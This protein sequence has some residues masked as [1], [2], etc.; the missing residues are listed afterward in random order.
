MITRSRVVSALFLWLLGGCGAD[1]ESDDLHAQTSSEALVSLAVIDNFSS[2][3]SAVHPRYPGKIGVYIE[4]Q[5]PPLPLNA[6]DAAPAGSLGT[7]YAMMDVG[8]NI[9]D[10]SLAVYGRLSF[11]NGSYREQ[12]A[13]VVAYRKLD[14]IG[15]PTG[16]VRFDVVNSDIGALPADR[17]LVSI[18]LNGITKTV[19]V[20]PPGSYSILLSSFPG[21]DVSHITSVDFG[22]S[23]GMSVGLD[24]SFDNLAI[25]GA[26]STCSVSI[27]STRVDD[28]S[29]P[30]SA[31]HPQYPG[32]LGVDSWNPKLTQQLPQISLDLWPTGAIGVRHTFMVVDRVLYDSRL[33]SGGLLFFNN[34]PEYGASRFTIAYN[35]FSPMALPVDSVFHFDLVHSDIASS[36]PVQLKVN[37]VVRTIMVSKPGPYE[38]PLRLF[39]SVN[40]KHAT[41]FDFSFEQPLGMSGLDVA[42]DNFR[43]DSTLA[44]DCVDPPE[45]PLTVSLLSATMSIVEG[46]ED[47]IVRAVITVFL[48]RPSDDEVTVNYAT[49]GDTALP[50]LD[51]TSPS[52]QTISGTLVFAPGET[53]KT[54][55]IN[56]ISDTDPEDDETFFVLLSNPVNAQLGI[57]SEVVTIVNDDF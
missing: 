25:D 9:H 19:K 42:F 34:G 53:V 37:G 36:V 41:S 13:F 50:S 56:I 6:F 29:S 21:L 44:E 57:A 5:S 32:V 48:N 4:E 40:L 27:V 7:R 8:P 55:T 22:F 26:A 14:V 3:F 12:S 52:S 43:I 23:T 15:E 54:Y 1:V 39:K 2:P 47:D 16:S 10:T 24:I 31:T 45:P 18:A 11:S 17:R 33:I 28:F 51:Y 38:I 46:N 30:F 20:G 49:V 35:A